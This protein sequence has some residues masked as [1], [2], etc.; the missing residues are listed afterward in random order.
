MFK[1]KERNYLDIAANAFMDSPEI[2]KST[3]TTKTLSK[4]ALGTVLV[5]DA[6]KTWTKV[7]RLRK[8]QKILNY[9]IIFSAVL[10]GLFKIRKEYPSS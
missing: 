3:N 4:I 2:Q 8:Y 6:I 10:Y 5:N 9:G 7:Q 1:T